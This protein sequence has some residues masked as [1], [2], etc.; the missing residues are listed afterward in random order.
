M[1]IIT[2]SKQEIIKTHHTHAH[3][4]YTHAATQYKT[5]FRANTSVKYTCAVYTNHVMW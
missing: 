1:I 3:K 2:A 5:I 4:K